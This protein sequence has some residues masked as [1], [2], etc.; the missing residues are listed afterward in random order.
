MDTSTKTVATM[1]WLLCLAKVYYGAIAGGSFIVL[2]RHYRGECSIGKI[3][4]ASTE[5]IRH[6]G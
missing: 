4:L 1:D 2:T 6:D 5:K 3:T